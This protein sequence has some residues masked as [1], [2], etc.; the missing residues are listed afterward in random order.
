VTADS[1]LLL[2][3]REQADQLAFPMFCLSLI[4]LLLLAGLIVVWVDIPR[5]VE[6]A[7]V[8]AEEAAQQEATGATQ[9]ADT[10]L[11]PDSGY[12]SATLQWAERIGTYILGALLL[13]WPLFIIEYMVTLG[14]W[15]F[16]RRE[17]SAAN[18]DASESLSRRFARAMVCLVPPL[19]LAAQSPVWD[20]RIWLPVLNWQHPGRELS[21]TLEKVTSKPMLIIALL[22][23]PI[24]L[25]EFGLSSMIERHGWL[26]LL[27]HISTGFIWWAFTVE[28]IT[29]ISATDKKFAYVKKHWIDLAIILLPLL[30]FLRSLRFLRLA[31]LAKVQKIAKMGRIYRMRGLGMKVFKAMIV[32]GFMQ[33]VLRVTPEKRLKKLQAQHEEKAIELNELE[34]EIAEL[35]SEIARGQG[36]SPDAESDQIA[37][38]D[39][40]KPDSDP[41]TDSGTDPGTEKTDTPQQRSA[42]G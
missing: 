16:G 26:R 41:G 38:G 10:P 3:R 15:Q 25:I 30:S 42:Q 7:Q 12:S 14:R 40:G 23:L 29:M 34:A 32:V 9:A 18:P 19:R 31:R 1:Q 13:L 39:S 33:R 4:F 37:A 5:V 8:T 17:Q 11:A 27:L 22:I 36:V 2:A 35:Q 21:K 24:L 28:F 6:L 20:N